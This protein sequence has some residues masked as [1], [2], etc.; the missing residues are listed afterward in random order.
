MSGLGDLATGL[1]KGRQLRKS[2]NGFWKTPSSG[3]WNSETGLARRT[4]RSLPVRLRIFCP[5]STSRM[6]SYLWTPSSSRL[7][8]SK[9]RVAKSPESWRL[10]QS[11]LQPS[12][13]SASSQE[14]P[15]L[16]SDLQAGG[17]RRRSVSGTS[18][19]EP[20]RRYFSERN[21]KDRPGGEPVPV[22]GCRCGRPPPYCLR[23]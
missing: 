12:S 3:R 8:C 11:L 1:R 16:R 21:L 22:A 18:M 5:L 4:A 10:A 2:A 17:P 9:R 19:T 15:S 13:G 14:V 6:R 7:P 23:P 20:R